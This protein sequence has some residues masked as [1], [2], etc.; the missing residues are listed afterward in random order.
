[1]VTKA[2][3]KGLERM[4]ALVALTDNSE[5]NIISCLMAENLNVY[6]TIALV[7]NVN[8]THISQNIGVDTIINKKLIAANNICRFV[9]KGKVG[10]VASLH[11]VD[12]EMSEFEID[13]KKI[14][15]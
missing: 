1:M 5:T 2:Y 13:K 14:P 9:R 10:V 6:K 8:Y 11:G 7:N 3:S 12:G 15:V 4:D